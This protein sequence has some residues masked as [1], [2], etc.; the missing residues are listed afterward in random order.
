MKFFVNFLSIFRIFAS[1]FI[2][3][4]LMWQYFEWTFALFVFASISDWLDGFLAR[5]FK[6]VTKIGGVLDHIGDKFLV[7]N[8]LIMIIMFLQIWAVIIPSIIM[9]CRELYVSGLREFLGMHKIQMPVPKFRFSFGKIKTS[10]QMLGAVFLL[11]WIWAVNEDLASEFMTYDLL[12]IGIGT[13]WFATLASIISAI[14]YTGTF[15]KNLKKI[16]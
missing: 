4:L 6:T 16:K 10:L 14:Q 2:I 9:I 15:I 8:S 13:L 5:K 11:L 7:V 12:F 1:F 3:P